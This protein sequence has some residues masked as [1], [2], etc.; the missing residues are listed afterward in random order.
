MPR[1]QAFLLIAAVL[2]ACNATIEARD[3]QTAPSNQGCVDT[4]GDGVCDGEDLCPLSNPNDADADEVCDDIDLCLGFNDLF[5]VDADGTPDGCDLCPSDA[6]DDT[7]GD[8]VCD[9]DDACEGADDTLDTD[10]DGRPDGCD[11]CPLDPLDDSD[12]DQVCDS[13]DICDGGNDSQD[14][15]GDGVPNM[16]DLCPLDNPDDT[17]GDGSCDADDPCPTDPLD[18]CPSADCQNG[19]NTLHTSPGG[20]MVVCDDPSDATCEEDIE[21]LCPA[22]WHLCTEPEF[23]QRNA[24]WNVLTPEVTVGAIHCRTGSGAGHYTLYSATTALDVDS[25]FNCN[26]G[27]SRA[28]CTTT[29][30]CNELTVHALCCRPQTLCG[31]GVV[32]HPEELCDDGNLDETDACLNSC[33]W[34]LPNDWGVSGC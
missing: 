19:S 12:G 2:A 27:S 23:T 3:P 33:A 4:D 21:Q 20:D 9:S 1:V 34:R 6:P 25:A 5:D 32:N 10:A 31:D 7:D 18:L 16:C 24:G 30:G 8:G 28:T 17:D 22:T 15:D 14:V 26:Y 13:D 11:T 29:Y